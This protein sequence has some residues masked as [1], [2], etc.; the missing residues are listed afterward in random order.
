ML[1]ERAAANDIERLHATT[2]RQDRQAVGDGGLQQRQLE[3]VVPGIDAFG[4]RVAGGAVDRRVDIRA[5][6]HDQRI[7]P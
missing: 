2:D 7:D 6:H 5:A 4:L 1:Q 3:R